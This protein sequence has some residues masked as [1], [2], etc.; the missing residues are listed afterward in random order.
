MRGKDDFVE[1]DEPGVKR[2][3]QFL[4][5]AVTALAGLIA[6]FLLVR[7]SDAGFVLYKEF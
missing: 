3:R 5:L 4:L 1:N 6:L 7:V 2:A